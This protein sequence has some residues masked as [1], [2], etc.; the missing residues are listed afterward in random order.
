MKVT[1]PAL[2]FD[3]PP[4]PKELTGAPSS[5]LLAVRK[6]DASLLGDESGDYIDPL[7]GEEVPMGKR[8]TWVT[9]TPTDLGSEGEDT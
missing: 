5:R 3:V 7:D 9:P 4:K 1:L 2:P 8:S 6:V